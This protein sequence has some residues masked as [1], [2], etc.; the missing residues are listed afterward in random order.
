MGASTGGP[1]HNAGPDAGALTS[2]PPGTSAV[3]L[4]PYWWP[5][6]AVAL[7]A[8]QAGFL[9]FVKP[10]ANLNTYSN[11]VNVVYFFVLLLAAGIFTLNAI[12]SGQN[13]RL[14]W[15]FV[16]VACGLRTLNAWSWVHYVAILGKGHPDFLFSAGPLGLHTIL[17][18]AAVASRPHLKLSRVKPYRTTLNL[19]FLLFFFVFAY[20]IV[21]FPV[22]PMQYSAYVLRAQP[23]YS[24]G[25]LLLLTVLGAVLVGSRPPW[26]AIYWHLFGA[27]SLY[28][29]GSLGANLAIAFGRIS[30]GWYTVAY[31]AAAYWL[32]WVALQGWELAPQ[33]EQ[34]AQVDTI[35][36]KHVATLAMLAVVAF[37]IVGVWE[38]FRSDRPYSTHVI[39]LLI[40]FLALLFLAVTAFINEYFTKRELYSDAGIARDRLQMAMAS[41]RS[42]GWEWNL[43]SGHYVWF[44]DLQTMLGIPS[45]ITSGQMADFDRYVHPDDRKRVLEAV[46]D[47]RENHK[48]YEAEFRVVRQAGTVHWVAARGAFYYSKNG[49]PERML[50][51]AVDITERKQA[52]EAQKKSEEMFS[53]AFRESPIA[54]TLTSTKDHRYLDVNETFERITGWHRDEVIGRTPF[55]L[56]IWVNPAQRLEV[57]EQVLASGVIRDLEFRFRCKDGAERVGFGSAELIEIEN[58]P[59]ILSAIADITENKQIQEKLRESEKRLSNIIGS[60]MDA[61]IAA[62]EEQQI[63][64]FNTAAEKMFGCTAGEAIG[65]DVNRFVPQRFASEHKTH[66]HLFGESGISSRAMGRLGTLRAV[67]ANGE[68]FPIE[69]SISQVETEGKRLFTA[70]IRDVTE[71]CQAEKALRDSEER[72]RSLIAS[73][74][75][76]VWEVD[77]DGVYTYA[78]PQCRGILGYEPAELIGKTPFD[79]MP[80]DESVRV[81]AIFNA[82]AAE[83]KT[84][85]GLE[86][87]NLHKDGHLVV[88]E[89]N[90]VPIL[91]DQGQFH[92]Y[93]GMDRDITERRQAE[94]LI[95]ESEQRFR[96]VA[97]TAPVLIWMSDPDRLCNYFNQ[98]W[99][100][101]TGRPL[102]AELGNGW[103]EGV[104]PEDLNACLDAYTL[105]FDRRVSFQ[106]MYRLRRHD[107]EYRWVQ[108]IGVPRFNPDG[109]FAGYIGSCVDVTD[110]KL[111]EEALAN[112]GRKLIEAHEEER[113]WIARE[114]HDD[115]NQRIALLT[116]ELE[117]WNQHVPGSA[118]DLHE[119]IHHARQRLSDISK[120][121]QSLSHR[122]HS[123]K[124]EYLGIVA[125]AS[126]FCKELSEQQKV[127]VEFSHSD[128]PHTVPWE[129]SLCVFRVLQE[130]L[131]NAVKHSGD[132]HIKVE[133]R[134]A[135]DEIQLTVS[136]LGSGFDPQ[137]SVHSRGLGLISMRERL[138]L[139]NGELSIKSAPGR[140]TTIHAR[141][142]FRAEGQLRAAG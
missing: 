134:G 125:A 97:N 16:A 41:G 139:V 91:D 67:R 31:T 32:V 84:F 105:A 51:I 12:R 10:S 19:L 82:I 114:L 29:L 45:D 66:I 100:D 27:S 9:T 129:I 86:N 108:D 133:L 54:L 5:V 95:R 131:Q 138:R 117:R 124:L 42:V 33:L 24:V 47:A 4:G 36:P 75:D 92:G 37:P 22:S 49:D 26:K 122:L 102:E 118:V 40:V 23:L 79:L 71:R 127:L 103:A 142:P 56:R 1:G 61:I 62:D 110:R 52:E 107:G 17:L 69:V 20:A 96:L 101:F 128:M 13:I 137:N 109:S 43:V 30:A 90:G 99:L 53:K 88:L 85:R 60:A 70:I 76:W 106:L 73:A 80:P 87:I 93:R 68:E 119:H 25:N 78:A 141:V 89:T 2:E 136:D 18:I 64:L 123:S 81:A 48:P 21:L 94:S 83:R 58:E 11:V 55:D 126:S 65:S 7:L 77:A 111:A 8:I 57:A 132:R 46:T 120:D 44:G 59:C 121:I 15:S 115:I 14:F 3:R 113:T 38:L 6:L 140:G 50:G 130:A 74:N 34:T 35:N 104:H 28:A 39:R 72:Y 63:V 135:P 98:P 116:I 112:M